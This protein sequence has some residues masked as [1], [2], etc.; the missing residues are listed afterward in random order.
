MTEGW[1]SPFL[2]SGHTTAKESVKCVKASLLIDGTGKAPTPDPL[3]LIE[4]GLIKEVGR[5]GEVEVPSE[6][7][8]IDLGERTILPGL[9]DAHV[10]ISGARSYSPAERIITPHDLMVIRAVEDCQ[11]LL[12]AGFTTIRDCGSKVSLSLKRAINDG[13]IPGPR[14]FAAGRAISQ[15]GGHSDT[16]YLPRE[17]VIRQGTLL[18]D[19]PD[20]C[21][22]A[23]RET[24]RDGADLIKIM[25]TGGVGSEK[26]EPYHPQ[27][28]V[29]EI[30]AITDEA[31]RVGK[32]VA[33]HA[34][35]A[36]GVKNAVTGGVDSIEHGYFLDSEAVKM[37][38]EHG[39]FFV[40]T[41]A[42]V[43]VYKRSLEKPL[44]MPPWRLRKQR[45]CTDAMPKSFLMAYQAGV[46][47]ATGSDYF[48]APM[49]AHG[50]NADEPIT[51]VEHGMKS[52]D[53]IVA[54][55]KN[56]A[57][58]IGVQDKVGTVN[59]GKVADI[60]GVDG[61]PITDMASLKRVAFIMKEGSICL[62]P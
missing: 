33:A 4:D 28:T 6:A 30:R 61:N 44:D 2:L 11:K 60:I 55:T 3:I 19:G 14:I 16:H 38:I 29:E 13:V 62:V 41:L 54:A 47:I 36:E 20:D 17:E 48:G 50:D 40:P 37:M 12:R 51:M 24:L 56:G 21:R 35:G 27:F 43:K 34:Q 57:E 39:T 32:R 25:A 9:I 1:S 15:T 53:A 42:L 10:H 59:V 49:R 7:R 58:C 45:E 52:M 8:I 46:K 23:A 26:D 31:H 5:E 22:R 18:A